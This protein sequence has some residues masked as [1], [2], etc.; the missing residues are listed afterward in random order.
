MAVRETI[1]LNF[2]F[3]NPNTREETADFLVK[4]FIEVNKPK[5]K[6]AIYKAAEEN[7]AKQPKSIMVQLDVDQAE[8][9]RESTIKSKSRTSKKAI[10]S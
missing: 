8:P 7:A 2:R 5:V 6:T 10:A 4:L 9:K 1:K 3:H